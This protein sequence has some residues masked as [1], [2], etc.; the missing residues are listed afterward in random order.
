MGYENKYF[1]KLASQKSKVRIKKIHTFALETRYNIP[2]ELFFN[3]DITKK[4][5]IESFITSCNQNKGLFIKNESPES[6]KVFKEYKYIYSYD[7][8]SDEKHKYIRLEVN[9][10]NQ[11]IEMVDLSTNRVKYEGYI[12]VSMSS[13]ILITQNTI[14]RNN[15]IFKIMLKFLVLDKI[16]FSFLGHKYASNE[17]VSG[18]G[19]LSKDKLSNEEI[20]KYLDVDISNFSTIESQILANLKKTKI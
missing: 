15:I 16:P 9:I 18:Y 7:K 5:Q 20:E 3:P 11:H 10:D 8:N 6:L 12:N 1:Y 17:E 14:T 13:I 2:N 4:S 19:L